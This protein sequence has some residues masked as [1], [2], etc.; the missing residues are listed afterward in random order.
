MD[1]VSLTDELDIHTY[2]HLATCLHWSAFRLCLS[3]FP[4]LF[5]LLAAAWSEK[6][7]QGN[8]NLQFELVAPSVVLEG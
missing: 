4:T 7:K 6:S 1:T 5:C 3:E 2:I 8:S